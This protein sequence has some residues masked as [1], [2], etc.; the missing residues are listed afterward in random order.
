M[1]KTKGYISILDYS[2]FDFSV[3]LK[4]FLNKKW[5]KGRK[6]RREGG[7]KERREVDSFLSWGSRLL[8][9][10][11]RSVAAGLMWPCSLG[12]GELP[13]G[14]GREWGNAESKGHLALTLSVEGGT[15]GGVSSPLPIQASPWLPSLLSSRECRCAGI[16]MSSLQWDKGKVLW[17]EGL[18]GHSVPPGPERRHYAQGQRGMVGLWSR[19]PCLSCP[20]QH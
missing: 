16:S 3:S 8:E 18:G 14:G 10:V 1:N 20:L 4:L 12:P 2:Y 17:S 19:P 11:V 13:G 6:D 15:E 9:D 5:K 7:R